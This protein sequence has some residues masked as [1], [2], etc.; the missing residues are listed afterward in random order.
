LN[1]F[2]IDAGSGMASLIIRNGIYYGRHVYRVG[3][4]GAR[5]RKEKRITLQTTNVSIARRRLVAWEDELEASKWGE[6]PKLKFEDAAQRFMD[7][8]CK[9]L[10]PRTVERYESHLLRLKPY[11][12]GKLIRSLSRKDLMAFEIGRRQDRGRCPTEKLHPVSIKRDLLCLSSMFS[13]WAEEEWVDFNPVPAFLKAR[14]KAGLKESQP[15]RRYLSHD[16][17][18][19]LI[20]AALQPIEDG[21]NPWRSPGAHEHLRRMLHVAIVTAID[22]GL[23]L[24]ELFSL[25]WAQVQLG[26]DAHV[27]VTGKG[28][29]TRRVP[30]F[31]RAVRALA[32]LSRPKFG[33]Y[34]FWWA[35]GRRFIDLRRSFNAACERARIGDLVWHDLRRTCGCRLL[36]DHNVRLEDVQIWLGHSS[37]KTTERHYAFLREESLSSIVQRQRGVVRKEHSAVLTI[38]PCCS[39]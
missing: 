25:T 27:V 18:N 31:D 15:R 30:L 29:K 36:Q 28:G 11:F 13:Y 38:P 10:R 2:G 17:E 19:R 12:D 32:D 21:E 1:G 33:D 35:R 14:R 5:V 22:T 37:I 6:C 23:R 16:E 20:M 8:H 24:E 3:P 7:N 4:K 34:V 9:M 26:G 39:V